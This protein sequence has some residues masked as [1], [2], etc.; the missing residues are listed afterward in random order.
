MLGSDLPRRKQSKKNSPK[1]LLS[2]DRRS[3]TKK[4]ELFSKNRFGIHIT[5]WIR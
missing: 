1:A 4:K 2:H 3:L 5:V